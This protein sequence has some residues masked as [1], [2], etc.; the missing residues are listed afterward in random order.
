MPALSQRIFLPCLIF[1]RLNSAIDRQL[2]FWERVYLI[3]FIASQKGSEPSFSEWYTKQNAELLNF[4][5]ELD[6]GDVPLLMTIAELRG[7]GRVME[8]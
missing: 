6:V 8:R 4:P 2:T 5:G 3:E 7:I 1:C